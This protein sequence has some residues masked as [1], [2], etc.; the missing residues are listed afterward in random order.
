[1]R[2]FRRS[3][4]ALM[5]GL[6]GTGLF[7]ALL[8]ALQ[9]RWSNLDVLSAIAIQASLLVISLSRGP[10]SKRGLFYIL[11]A[12]IG[13]FVV[14]VA[15]GFFTEIT[16]M[17]V[18]GLGIYTFI[19]SKP[20]FPLT[21]RAMVT[22]IAVGVIMTFLG[23]Y[24]ALKIGVVYFIGAEL[25]GAIILSMWGRYTPEENTIVVA[26]A[27]SSGFISVGV[28]VVFPAVAIF[29]EDTA[30]VNQL[31]TVPFIAVVTAMSAFFGIILLVPFRESFEDDP[32]PQIRPQAEC[33]IA[34]G[35]DPASKANVAMGIGASAAWVATTKVVE[36]VSGSSLASIPNALEPVIPAAGS[37]PDW[38][39][40]ANSPLLAGIGY[41]VGWKRTL[42]L[43]CGTLTTMMFWIV[44]E[45][46]APIPYS[47]HLHRP[48]IIYLVLGVFAS[49]I[50]KDIISSRERELTP[51]EFKR[52]AENHMN[53]DSRGDIET[54]LVERPHKAE[55]IPKLLRVKE[56]LFSVE[57]LRE[58]IIEMVRNPR[59][60]MR[61]R[62]GKMP[63]W[64]AFAS[65][66]LFM[67]T[68]IIIFSILTPFAGV[69][70]PWALFVFGTPLAMVSAYFTAR[71][72]SETGMLA[73]YISD[74]ISIPAILFFR[75]SFQAITTFMA[76]LGGLQD[77]ALALLVHLK[78]GR[79]TGV[80]GRD[81]LKAVFIGMVLGTIAG[82]VITYMLFVTYGFGGPDF[83]AP[84]AQLF[85]FL[86]TSIADIGDFQLPGVSDLPGFH[87]LVALIYLLSFGI[88]G[89]IVGLQLGK[90]G[91][92][93]ISL[94]VGLL[95]PPA[96]AV[97]MLFGAFVDFR[98]E[99]IRNRDLDSDEHISMC[100]QKRE[101]QSQVLSGVVAGE[102][103]V[104]VVWVIWSALALFV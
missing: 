61:S 5:A 16:V 25:L 100:E 6:F 4:R 12:A 29:V 35:S 92:S 9:G 66:V 60:Y 58:E 21:K 101:K 48:E 33:I 87:P 85:G 45:G 71:S 15:F 74:V 91:L 86:V 88:I 18:G 34:L 22:G 64:V 72:I 104:T 53:K 31:I 14:S 51:A 82:S 103:I 41:F 57:T 65:M 94:A 102:A 70:L 52:L 2:R 39:G 24:L 96:T 43:L 56:E 8:V 77:A 49:V 95:I 17:A 75:V 19:A 38:I 13:Y 63:P 28:L 26:I 42:V 93:A 84:V 62:R 1:M 67:I 54:Q 20:K 40:V 68:G 80:R 81:I 30:L 46:A 83:P 73:G 23:I 10:I 3:T 44:L 79:F 98:M 36:Q 11:L 32:W 69:R 76:M 97:A 50:F 47:D 89:G 90:R 78:L 99:R 27:N 55:D 59:E 37:I 7:Y